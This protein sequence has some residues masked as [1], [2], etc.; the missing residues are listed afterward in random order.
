M[1]EKIP[2]YTKGVEVVKKAKRRLG[3]PYKFGAERK[4]NDGAKLPVDCS[5]LVQVAFAEAGLEM[6]DGSYNQFNACRKC[7]KQ[8][9]EGLP[10]VLCFWR[11][12]KSSRISHV[13]IATGQG[14]VIE[15][16][17]PKVIV[18]DIDDFAWT[19]FGKPKCI[20]G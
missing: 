5:E 8:D 6:P 2:G 9:A 13:G 1:N 14:N 4:K 7:S 12:S 11:K 3:A 17:P 16:T 18:R 15:A 19:E 10:G 20:Y